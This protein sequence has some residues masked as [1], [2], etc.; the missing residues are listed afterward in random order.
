MV[1]EKFFLRELYSSYVTSSTSSCRFTKLNSKFYFLSSYTILKGNT[2]NVEG[3]SLKPCRCIRVRSKLSTF[4]MAYMKPDDVPF[5][6]IN[7][8]QSV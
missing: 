6:M 7:V 3:P 4:R 2:N 8:R 1:S 5:G